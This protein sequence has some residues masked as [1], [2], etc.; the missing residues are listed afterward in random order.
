MFQT[1]NQILE[2]HHQAWAQPSDKSTPQPR[3]VLPL[4]LVA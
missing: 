3:E 1:T 2:D 4:L